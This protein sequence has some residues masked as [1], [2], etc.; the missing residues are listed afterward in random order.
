MKIG[1]TYLEIFQIKIL[2]K[3]V[4]HKIFD[5]I[6]TLMEFPEIGARLSNLTDVMTEHRFLVI[7]KYL[8]FYRF[9]DQTVYIDRILSFRQNYLRILFNAK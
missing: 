1:H 2:Q 8:A 6:E 4:I 5:S 3:N 7:D 9:I